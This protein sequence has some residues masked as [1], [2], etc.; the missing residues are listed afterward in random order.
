[1]AL[2]VDVAR[3]YTE[4]LR[5]QKAADQAAL[6]GVVQAGNGNGTPVAIAAE[7]SVAR[8]MLASSLYTVEPSL[9][10]T[11]SNE[12]TAQ[13]NEPAFPLVFARLLGIKTANISR[14]G[15]AQY[16]APVPMGNPS[17]TLGDPTAPITIDQHSG[18]AASVP[19]NMTLAVNG[20]DSFR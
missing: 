15:V 11:P 20:P 18:V 8:N 7:T 4:G 10:I 17:N 5:V 19:E 2:G 13:I 6:A 16:N 12:V 1:M 14:V 3:I 9:V